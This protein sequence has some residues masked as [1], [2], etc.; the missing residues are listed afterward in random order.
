MTTLQKHLDTQAM[1]D[2][3]K[4]CDTV[5]AFTL[6]T[7][8]L[9]AKIWNLQWKANTTGGSLAYSLQYFP[10]DDSTSI[11]SPLSKNRMRK[12]G[13][14][15]VNSSKKF[16]YFA[17]VKFYLCKN[18]SLADTR[19]GRW[20]TKMTTATSWQLEGLTRRQAELPKPASVLSDSQ[21]KY[22]KLISDVNIFF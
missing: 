14:E 8:V 1:A 18:V 15:N 5:S 4:N 22:L 6:R 19:K 11:L 20:K 9:H 21:Y 13:A 10:V 3:A 17:V 7:W 2:T 16:F 12:G